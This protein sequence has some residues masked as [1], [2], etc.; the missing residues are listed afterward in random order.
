MPSEASWRTVRFGTP[1]VDLS[2]QGQDAYPISS[3][4]WI[5]VPVKSADAS[6]KQALLAFLNWGLTDGQTFADNLPYS[7][8]PDAVVKKT[9]SALSQI[10]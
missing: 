6:K 8:L 2:R 5:I 3:F 9:L 10:Q 4:T 7:R 1:P